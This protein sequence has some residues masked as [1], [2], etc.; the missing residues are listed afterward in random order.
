MTT[1]SERVRVKRECYTLGCAQGQAEKALSVCSSHTAKL[2]WIVT[3]ST[4]HPGKRVS[5]PRGFVPLPPERNR[6]EVRRVGL[7]EQSVA[8]HE[9]KQVVVSPLVE[10]HDSTKRHIP[11]CAKGEL[12]QGMR[13]G[14][15]M[16]HTDDAGV[17]CLSDQ[18]SGVVFRLARVDDDGLSGLASESQLRGKCRALC[19]SRRI[20]VVVIEAALS[21]RYRG[22]LQQV[23]KSRKIALLVECCRVVRMDSRRRE[24]KSR[25]LGRVFRRERRSLERLPD[26]DDSRRARI[27]GAGDYRVAVA[28]EGRVR[29]VGVAVDED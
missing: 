19:L 16:Q 4:R 23:A 12:R 27:A 17:S 24:N 20:I 10:G 2:Q 1:I 9:P 15:T 18:R 29:E 25:I 26:A 14:V 3:A 28:G 8:R 7:D 13:P 21:N 6:R 11:S 22:S 5:D